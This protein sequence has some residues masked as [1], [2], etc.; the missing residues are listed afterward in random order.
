M[1]KKIAFNSGEA[2]EVWNFSYPSYNGVTEGTTTVAGPEYSGSFTHFG[3]ASNAPWKIGLIKNWSYGD[4]SYSEAYAWAYQQI[5]NQTW[6]VLGVSMG[7][8]KAPV[9]SS[10]ETNRAGDATLKI[11]YLYQ[12][13]GTKR[14]GL[15]TRV[16]YYVNG[17]G[18]LKYYLELQYYYEDPTR[19]STWRDTYY[20][21]DYLYSEIMRDGNGQMMAKTLTNYYDEAGKRGA[22]DSLVRYKNETE[23]Y[24]WDYGYDSDSP[25][26]VTI[27]GKEPFGPTISYKFSYGVKNEVSD[28]VV[29]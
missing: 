16:N 8:V 7:T 13:L 9:L 6:S 12:R 11:E 10:V 27:S 18:V 2:P 14:Y 4:G 3:Y 15:P 22:I 24:T 25:N 5:S 17:S 20:M 1:Q 23:F 21:L 19:I 26:L 28:E 29:N